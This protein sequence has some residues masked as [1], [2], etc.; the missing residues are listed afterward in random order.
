[1]VSRAYDYIVTVSNAAAFQKGNVFIGNVSSA[2]GVIANVDLNENN[3]K[4]KVDNVMQEFQVG[5]NVHSNVITS[6]GISESS[7][8]SNNT[9]TA[10]TLLANTA[11]YD[12]TIDGH[13]NVFLLSSNA[14]SKS[15]ISVYLNNVYIDH[16]EF[17]WPANTVAGQP[18]VISGVTYNVE[19]FANQGIVFKND[20]SSGNVLPR[21]NTT[22]LVIFRETSNSNNQSFTGNAYTTI[23]TTALSNVLAVYNN[24][25]IKEKNKLQQNPL[26]RMYSIYYPGEWYPGTDAGNPSN[27]GAGLPWPLNFPYRIAEVRG[28]TISDLQ[29]KAAYGGNDFTALPIDSSSMEMDSTGRV[30]ELSISISNF[31]NSITALV[32]DPFLVGN[33]TS[34]S[35][36]GTVNGEVVYGLD[37]RTVIGNSHYDSDVVNTY[38]GTSNAPWIYDQA[39]EQGETWSELKVD[40]RDLLGAVVE[41]ISTYANFLDY[42][43]EYSSIRSVSG[44]TVELFSSLPYRVGDNVFVE[45]NTDTS[46][47]VR[48]ITSIEESYVQFESALPNAYAGKNLYIMNPDKDSEAYVKDVFKIDALEGLNEQV[49][50][51]S[52]T[53]WLQYFK[54]QLPKRKYF[55]NTCQWIYKGTECQYP[56]PGGLAI[57]GTDKVSNTDPITANNQEGVTNAD[58]DCAKSYEA[59]QL[60]NN[61]LHF[62]GFIGTGRTIPKQ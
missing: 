25:L 28:D 15:E 48:A 47:N 29:Y 7:I 44:N 37:P 24:P 34:N 55:K 6:Y 49:A 46:E 42:W 58:D 60:R 22:S 50:T 23:T 27:D 62:G 51:F 54:L 3:I 52:L 2:F 8:F 57:P 35:A 33:V 20:S 11:S 1:M 59:C 41:I 19:A 5:E 56:G 45:G 21:A 39:V 18:G 40:S 31:D 38:Y 43:P 30:N 10:V 13:T 61:T 9:T 26:V 53:S 32:E 14:N 17:V 12:F 4:V 16:D 36:Q